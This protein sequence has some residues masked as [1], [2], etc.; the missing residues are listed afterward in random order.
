MPVIQSLRA[1]IGRR[2]RPHREVAV[3][4][5]DDLVELAHWIEKPQLRLLVPPSLLRMQGGFVYGPRHP[6]VSAL[7][8]GRQA[9]G[10][11]YVSCRPASICDYY[12]IE[13]RGRVGCDLPPWELPWYGRSQRSPPPGELDLG[14]EH[15]VS[16]YGPV[17]ENKITLEMQRLERLVEGIR[18]NGYD[19]DAF[20][21]V[22]GY[23]LDDGTS[24]AFFVRGG[25]HRVAAM[26]VLGY[27]HVPVA[28]RAA[29]PRLVHIG[30]AGRWP[31]VRSG[32]MEISLA[33]EILEAYTRGRK[34]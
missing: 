15:G 9:L 20:G 24:A 13:G 17:T 18:R 27:S 26:T 8:N 34:N 22:E 4:T 23:I 25:K 2:F 28:F 12:G 11:F 10:D 21:D 31:L 7:T 29:W 6:F 30:D 3:E 32:R 14:P 1:T 19:P 5:A 33:K 16:F